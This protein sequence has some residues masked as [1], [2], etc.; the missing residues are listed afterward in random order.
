MW[1]K[2]R[3]RERERERNILW[4]GREIFTVSETRVDF[5]VSQCKLFAKRSSSQTTHSSSHIFGRAPSLPRNLPS[6]YVTTRLANKIIKPFECEIV[7]FMALAVKVIHR[8]AEN[9]VIHWLSGSEKSWEKYETETEILMPDSSFPFSL[10]CAL[11][12]NL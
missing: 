11:S 7:W 6:W 1:R 8:G 2:G 5:L 4:Y 10:I 12:E 3:E 9:S